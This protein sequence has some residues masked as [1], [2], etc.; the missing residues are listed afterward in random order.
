MN[1]V[2]RR[3]ALTLVGSLGVTL[4]GLALGVALVDALLGS[5]GLALIF[6][7]ADYLGTY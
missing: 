4:V 2:F 3:I 1:K 5:L 7:A 6:L